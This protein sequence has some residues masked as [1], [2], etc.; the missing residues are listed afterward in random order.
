MIWWRF[1]TPHAPPTNPDE[2][3]AFA[4]GGNQLSYPPKIARQNNMSSP[5]MRAMI[6]A[7]GPLAI[8]TALVL[9]LSAC[10]QSGI[11]DAFANPLAPGNSAV[12]VM[13]GAGPP[14]AKP[15][16]CYGR[17]STPAVIETVT[18]QVMVQPPQI[19]TDGSLREPAIFVT[20]THQRIVTERR[21][22][23]F[24]VP[25]A[26]EVQDADFIASLQR[27]LQVRDLYSGPI[28]GEMNRRTLRAVRAFQAPQGLDSEILSLAAAQQLG[29]ALW[30]PELAASPIR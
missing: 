15:T 19:T 26:L 28:T 2:R 5:K 9:G 30:N 13:R 14:N 25:C 4:A 20:E 1:M 10:S 21:E 22:L 23:W 29:L 17:K 27:T 24:E 11:G 3:D 7:P 18:E 8:T 16:S 6:S 12:E